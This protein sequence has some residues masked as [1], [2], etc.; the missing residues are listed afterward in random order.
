MSIFNNVVS[1]TIGGK[2]VKSLNCKGGSLWSASTEPSEYTFVDYIETDGNQCIDTVVLASDYPDGLYYYMNAHALGYTATNTYF[3]GALA[4]GSRSG[5]I[6]VN[7]SDSSYPL[8]L[9]IGGSSSYM[10]VYSEYPLNVDFTLEVTT[11]PSNPKLGT[12]AYYNGNSFSNSGQSAVVSGMP[13]AN[14]YLFAA[15][16]VAAT[17]GMFYGRLYSFKMTSP[18]KTTIVRNFRPCIRNSD[19]EVGLY[20]TVTGAFYGNIGTGSFVAGINA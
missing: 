7:T 5:N 14:I 13:S 4:D 11:N 3:F 6:A 1:M 12:T 8:R 17:N 10:K 2:S 19:N 20:D 15:N 9:L 18:D 16:G